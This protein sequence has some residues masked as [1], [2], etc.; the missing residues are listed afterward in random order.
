V[1]L[2]LEN[3]NQGLDVLLST[4][5]ALGY[6]GILDGVVGNK[7]SRYHGLRILKYFSDWNL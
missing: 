2:L 3:E 4:C 1:F 6:C 7:R 5:T